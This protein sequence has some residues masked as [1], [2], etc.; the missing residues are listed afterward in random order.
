MHTPHYSVNTTHYGVNT[1]HYGVNIPHYGVNA[2]HYGV[3]DLRIENLR[4]LGEF[5]V[6]LA[7][8]ELG[9]YFASVTRGVVA[10]G[11]LTSLLR[12]QGS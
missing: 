8:D 3:N 12:G 1:T 7:I 5:L 4:S 10:V 6:V 2:T 11:M 9:E